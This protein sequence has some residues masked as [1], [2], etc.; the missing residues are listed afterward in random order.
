MEPLGMTCRDLAS[1]MNISYVRLNEILNGRRGISPDT[2]MRLARV[3]DTSDTLWI[4][5]QIMLDLFD[6]RHSPEAKKIAKLRPIRRSA[7]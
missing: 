7:A 3:F 5:M 6:A 4:N 2:A 1:A